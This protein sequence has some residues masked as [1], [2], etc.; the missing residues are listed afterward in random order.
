[1]G[2]PGK[3]CPPKSLWL[4]AGLS[5]RVS[6]RRSLQNGPSSQ[7]TWFDL[8]S[9]GDKDWPKGLGYEGVVN[10]SGDEKS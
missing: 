6:Q 4:P 9:T 3:L 8:T 5:S 1:M 2:N 7:K 10:S